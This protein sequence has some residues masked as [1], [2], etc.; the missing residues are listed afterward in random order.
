M[1]Y[2]EILSGMLDAMSSGAF[3]YVI[4]NQAE[5]AKIYA[6]NITVLYQWKMGQPIIK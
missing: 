5:E 6:E 4:D 3:E 1:A 2:V